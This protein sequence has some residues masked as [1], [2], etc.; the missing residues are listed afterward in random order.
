VRKGE[1]LKESLEEGEFGLM[2]KDRRKGKGGRRKE[3]QT[4][5]ARVYTCELST[6]PTIPRGGPD[7]LSYEGSEIID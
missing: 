4:E 6:L 5:S 3:T 1:T 7:R 2:K